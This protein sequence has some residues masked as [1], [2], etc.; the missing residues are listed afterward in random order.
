LSSA[1]EEKDPAHIFGPR[2]KVTNRVVSIP[3]KRAQSDAAKLV[4][5][6]YVDRKMK[7]S[8]G[9]FWGSQNNRKS[10]AGPVLRRVRRAR[11]GPQEIEKNP[12]AVGGGKTPGTE[13]L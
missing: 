6:T 4:V 9:K 7:G 3:Q 1:R 10:N 13:E 12:P 8:G 11:G 5:S 2:K